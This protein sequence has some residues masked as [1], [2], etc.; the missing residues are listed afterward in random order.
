MLH[1]NKKN[2]IMSFAGKWIE[3]ETIIFSE[4]SQSPNV[5]YHGF[6]SIRNLEKVYLKREMA[7]KYTGDRKILE[8]RK[9]KERTM[10]RNNWEEEW[11][12]M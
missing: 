12:S 7:E 5:E 9:M 6:S 1:S 11:Q 4:I 2:G 8:K 10:G 3:P